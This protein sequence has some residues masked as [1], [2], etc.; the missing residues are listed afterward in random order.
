MR[1]T[2]G[3]IINTTL[4]GLYSNM[5]NINKTYAQ[6][7]TGKK[8]QTVSDDPIIAGRAL[9]LKT[10]VLETEQYQSNAKEALSFME[11]TEA[12]MKNMTEILKTIRTKCVQ[13]S[14][15]T[16]EAEDKETIK[17]EIAQLWK[18]IQQE[19]NGTYN[20]RYVFSG[21]KTSKP[22]VLDKNY[23]IKDNPLKVTYDTTIGSKSS[24]ADGTELADGSIVAAGSTIGKGSII[25]AGSELGK[26]T[27][28]SEA[29]AETMLGLTFEAGKYTFDK[30]NTL[31][32]DTVI[33]QDALDKLKAAGVT[34]DCTEIMD[35]NGVGTG[36]YTVNTDATI[37]VN[38]HLE[39]DV[40][41]ELFGL[42][43]SGDGTYTTTVKH[44]TVNK[45]TGQPY[46]LTGEMTVGAT[47]TLKAGAG[48]Q[49]ILKGNSTLA[50]NSVVREGS[51]LAVGSTLGKG[52]L[53]PE[54]VG[55]IDGQAIQYE[56][57][58][59]ST[60]TVNTEGMDDTFLQMEKSFNEMFLL[61]E[62]SLKDDSITTEQLHN[63]FTSMLD[64]IDDIMANISEKTSDLGSRE[65]RV[66]YVQSRLIDQKTSYKNLLSETEDVDIEEVYTNFNVQYATYQSALQATSKIITNT[67]ADYL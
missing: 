41:S 53:N 60:I 61:L 36:K 55:K 51:T 1:V 42:K 58:V 62:D 40:A 45:P 66:D 15:G 3:M 13:A 10:S 9:K 49:T 46:T 56:I 19:A 32:A 18:Q 59:N 16:L 5:N 4:N 64:E 63:K 24:V 21:Y 39:D 48:E 47:T 34:V 33:S 29:D 50:Q 11:I 8:I 12:S 28:L 65:S 43:S 17:T 6:M 22:L 31:K 54:V 25:N 44:T 37:P 67:L 20:G 2:N 35:E 23:E 14:T 52:T 57:G 7:V 38:T 30:E 26:G 27:V